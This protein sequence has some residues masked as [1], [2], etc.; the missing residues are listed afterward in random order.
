[1]SYETHVP[2]GAIILDTKYCEFCGCNFLRRARSKDRYCSKCL[3]T[4]LSLNGQKTANLVSE[5]IH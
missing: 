3:L 1:M 4:I 2:V 5:L